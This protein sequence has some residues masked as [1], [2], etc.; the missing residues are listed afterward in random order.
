MKSFALLLCLSVLLFAKIEN[1]K[2]IQ[3][4]FTQKVTNDQ[5]KTISYE[6]QFYA[7]QDKK[8]LWIYEKP[9]AKK[10]YF[11]GN[12]VVILEPELEQAIITT[13]EN[14]PNIALLLQ[15]AK[16]I[17]ANLYTTKYMET[18]YTIYATKETIERITYRDK[19][20]NSVEILFS[21]QS[22]NLFLD[23]ALFHVDIPKGYDIVRE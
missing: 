8:A 5:K 2:T 9:V 1:F 3:S 7:T 13:L 23:D 11:N 16:E 14:T 15:E 18:T 4:D 21:H 20:D 12:K 22:T 10:I 19:L 6:G 17:S